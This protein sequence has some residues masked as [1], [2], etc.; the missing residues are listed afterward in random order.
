MNAGVFGF[1]IVLQIDT[2]LR[3]NRVRIEQFF[4]EENYMFPDSEL[5]I[6]T[7]GRILEGSGRSV[8]DSLDANAEQLMVR[9]T[10]VLDYIAGLVERIVDFTV[11]FE[12]EPNESLTIRWTFKPQPLGLHTLTAIYVLRCCASVLSTY[13]TVASVVLLM[14]HSWP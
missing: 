5:L 14:L 8:N 6:L 10:M 4:A 2:C 13:N 3:R 9:Q 7:L 1:I 12:A 11:R